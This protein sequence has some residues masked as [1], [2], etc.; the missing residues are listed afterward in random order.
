MAPHDT[1]YLISSMNKWT[2]DLKDNISGTFPPTRG[3][4][5]MHSP[6]NP[7]HGGN[8]TTP[9]KKYWVLFHNIT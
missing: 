9:A 7:S 3:I 6:P 2:G 5:I 1:K 8:K 4:E